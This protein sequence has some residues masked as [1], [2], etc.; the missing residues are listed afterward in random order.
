[1]G[2]RPWD[3]EPTTMGC[4]FWLMCLF[5]A[6]VIVMTIAGLFKIAIGA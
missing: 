4:I 6:W 1:M 2:R 5:I 3:S